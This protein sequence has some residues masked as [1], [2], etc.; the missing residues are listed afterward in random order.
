MAAERE[1]QGASFWSEHDMTP[2][3]YDPPGSA[4]FLTGMYLAVNA[5]SDLYL[6]VD[7]P[8]CV[9]FRIP[10]LQANH[11]WQ[12]DLAR[13]SGLHRIVDTDATPTRVAQGD[14]ALLVE[15]LQTVDALPD[16]GAIL[17]TAMAHVAI[18]GRQYDVILQS[19]PAPLSH[20]VIRVPE[21]SLQG[22]WVAGYTATLE[23]LARELP[24][25]PEAP[26]T[27]TA[28]SRVAVVGHLHHRNEADVLADEAELRRLLTALELEVVS[29]WP[30]G[31]GVAAL[32]AAGQA[33]LVVSLPY[34]GRAGALLAERVGASVVQAD[35]P[36]GLEATGRFLE[37]VGE[38]AGRG[39]VA[40]R[41]RDEELRRIIPTLEWVLEHELLHR[42]VAVGTDPILAR[43]LG[44]ALEELGCVVAL[45]ALIGGHPDQAGPPRDEAERLV[46]PT[47]REIGA[48]VERVRTRGSLDLALVCSEAVEALGAGGP[49]VPFL[50]V[51]FPAYYTHFFHPTPLLGYAGVRSLVTRLI[52]EIRLATASPRK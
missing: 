7:G 49:P 2:G 18:T 14:P 46:G 23:A 45:E 20:P 52:N 8:N 5:V 15:R 41:V 42:R 50:E 48:A 6:V 12:A 31:Q 35:L 19:L 40:R 44:D 32:Q 10:Q 43:A 47:L 39:E 1:S 28:R 29:L 11:D 36:L 33:D 30:D 16:C 51:G 24:L 38:A 22:D 37:A 13:S 26:G 3:P 9:F 25:A 21:G 4:P 34:A 17:L 27:S